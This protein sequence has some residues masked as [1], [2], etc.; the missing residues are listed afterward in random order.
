MITVL[1][2]GYPRSFDFDSIVAYHG[3]AAPGGV[4]HAVKLMELAFARLSPEAPLERREVSV[5]TSFGGLGV[6]D[7]FEMVTR[8]LTEGRYEVDPAH[9][10]GFEDLGYRKGFV[11]HITYRG[12]TVTLVIREGI[13]RD[14]FL[15]LA[16]K[17]ADGRTKDEEMHFAWLREE[18]AARVM[19]LHASAVY[20]LVD[21]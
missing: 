15:V 14:E 19:K 10:T 16:G 6:R 17:G 4:A 20:E 9:G 7:A 5:K 2:Q 1:D 8:S 3:P 13:V 21:G 18:M 11:F 12:R